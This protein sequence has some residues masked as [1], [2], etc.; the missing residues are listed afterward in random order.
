MRIFKDNRNL[1][2]RHGGS[3]VLVIERGA[4]KDMLCLNHWKN[5]A[6]SANGDKSDLVEHLCICVK[7]AWIDATSKIGNR[8]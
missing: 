6:C 2:S 4:M 3:S 8:L 5:M 7:R 1:H